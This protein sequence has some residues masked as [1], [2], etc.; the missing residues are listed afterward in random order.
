MS[1]RTILI[2]VAVLVVLG[3]IAAFISFGQGTGVQ[4]DVST[5]QG[6]ESQSEDQ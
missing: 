6:L 2:I 5:P 3:A 1:G 4:R